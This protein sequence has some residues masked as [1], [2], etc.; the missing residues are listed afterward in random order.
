MP[1]HRVHVGNK[2]LQEYASLQGPAIMGEIRDL[3]P[4]LAGL[5]MLHLSATAYGGGVAEIMYTLAPLLRD[6]GIDCEWRILQGEPAFFDATKAIHN[7]LQGDP[8]G[9]TPEQVELFLRTN[10]ENARLLREDDVDTFDV[11]V[12]HDPQPAFVPHYLGD[13]GAHLVWRCHIDLSTPNRDVLDVLAPALGQYD[14]AIFHLPEFVPGGTYPAT[15]KS[16]CG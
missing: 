15:W 4:A 8:R 7:A 9:L 14:A 6:A 10:E 13:V 3:A 12:V 1:L 5:R 2:F 16:V 11:I